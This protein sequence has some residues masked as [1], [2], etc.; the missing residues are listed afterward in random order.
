MSTETGYLPLAEK[1]PP[2]LA[3]GVQDDVSLLQDIVASSVEDTEDYEEETRQDVYR[4]ATTLTRHYKEDR[5]SFAQIRLLEDKAYGRGVYGDYYED[6]GTGR[7]QAVEGEIEQLKKSVGDETLHSYFD[8][9]SFVPLMLGKKGF[10]LRKII[11]DDMVAHLEKRWESLQLPL[12]QRELLQGVV[13]LLSFLETTAPQ[14]VA[15]ESQDTSYVRRILVGSLSL[16]MLK[17][18]EGAPIDLY[19]GTED[20]FYH[21]AGEMELSSEALGRLH[22]WNRLVG[23]IDY[24]TWGANRTNSKTFF[25]T[26]D[27]EPEARKL[28]QETDNTGGPDNSIEFRPTNS[29]M[30][31]LLAVHIDGK[32]VFLPTM[33]YSLGFKMLQLMQRLDKGNISN[34]IELLISLAR[35]TATTEE[36][37]INGVRQVIL[38]NVSSEPVPFYDS[39]SREYILSRHH[40]IENY[41]SPSVQEFFNRVL[42]SDAD[43]HIIAHNED[44]KA[45]AFAILKRLKDVPEEKKAQEV[46]TILREVKSI[47]RGSY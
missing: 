35:S 17:A 45:Y 6:D 22:Q 12:E 9:P 32:K 41:I 30:N 34:D 27:L 36:S 19:Q 40:I 39:E 46:N 15:A 31:T 43:W 5:V 3:A 33:E 10:D 44:A 24:S 13:S 38:D 4:L 11:Q 7:F 2:K 23:D 16:W 8:D 47:Y 1:D 29:E 20:G 26:S 25:T 18:A 14:A 21:K 42:T 37:M 28:L